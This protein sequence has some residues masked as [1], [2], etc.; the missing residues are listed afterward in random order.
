MEKSKR[1]QYLL[2]AAML[3]IGCILYTISTLMINPVNIIPGSVLGIAV[4]THH[5]TGAPIGMVS[6]LCNIPIMFFCTACFGKKILIYT[7]LILVST[8]GLIDLWQPYFPTILSDHAWFLAITGGAL[9]GAGAGL[10][11]RAG[12]TMGGTTALGRLIQNRKPSVNMGIALFVMDT[13]IILV[14]SFL[15][16]SF[17]GL[18]YSVIYTLVCSKVI[19]V[20]YTIRLRRLLDQ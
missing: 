3:F 1:T 9:M 11:M 8:S 2:E 14:G 5:L 12:G 7:V 17:S 19:D 4:V 13:A 15:L 10:L 6:L 20:I 16:K 18:L